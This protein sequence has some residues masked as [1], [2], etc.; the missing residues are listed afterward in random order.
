MFTVEV[1]LNNDVELFQ[2]QVVFDGAVG[3][4]KK[5]MLTFRLKKKFFLFLRLF[6]N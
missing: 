2:I 1:V 4:E 6:T 3:S 5:K